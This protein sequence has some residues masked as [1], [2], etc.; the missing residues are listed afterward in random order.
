MNRLQAGRHPLPFRLARAGRLC[1]DMAAPLGRR[2][3]A[4]G[5]K[6]PIDDYACLDLDAPTL[7]AEEVDVDGVARFRVWCR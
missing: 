4:T 1:L 7:P 3:Q 5:M 2:S 6:V